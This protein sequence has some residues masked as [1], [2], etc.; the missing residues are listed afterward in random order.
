MAHP[1]KGVNG[2]KEL[3]DHLIQL[4]QNELKYKRVQAFILDPLA[5]G[6]E[7]QEMAAAFKLI[8]PNSYFAANDF[9]FKFPK[10]L[11]QLKAEDDAYYDRA[12][13]QGQCS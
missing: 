11:K 4:F 2:V 3:G 6:E 9:G 7:P 10:L 13:P 12:T 5:E 8:L 1:D